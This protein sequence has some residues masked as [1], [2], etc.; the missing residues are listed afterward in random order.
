VPLVL[1][2][3]IIQL[4]GLS[5][6]PYPAVQKKWYGN[7]TFYITIIRPLKFFAIFFYYLNGV[8]GLSAYFWAHDFSCF[9]WDLWIVYLLIQ[10]NSLLSLMWCLL[11]NLIMQVWHGLTNFNQ[12]VTNVI[13][14]HWNKT[15]Q[16]LWNSLI[17]NLQTLDSNYPFL[18]LLNPIPL[19]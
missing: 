18:T 16:F 3:I 1:M 4:Q 13:Y 19:S 7:D 5:G 6:Q 9:S 17:E 14:Y 15:V 11:C 10:I 12:F 8:L 2:N